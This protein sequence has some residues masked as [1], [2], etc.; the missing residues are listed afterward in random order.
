MSR[1]R[2]SKVKRPYE[3]PGTQSVVWPGLFRLG[4]FWEPSLSP[5]VAKFGELG[6]RVIAT[7]SRIEVVQLQIIAATV[8]EHARVLG[9]AFRE[10]HNR[11]TRTAFFGECLKAARRGDARLVVEV[12]KTTV[13]PCIEV[14]D[15]LAHWVWAIIPS[16]PD[17][18]VLIDPAAELN[19]KLET[20]VWFLNARPGQMRL[21]PEID[22]TQ[23]W[24]YSLRDLEAEV[25]KAMTGLGAA[26]LILELVRDKKRRKRSGGWPRGR[27]C[28]G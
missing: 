13:S 27:E 17:Y 5:N 1:R 15:M 25:T 6:A 18:L 24:A 19:A 4:T 23:A 12:W 9:G 22:M 10:V 7:V 3:P 21:A 20:Q 14:R 26:D 16:R 2:L 28:R 11:G 8:Q